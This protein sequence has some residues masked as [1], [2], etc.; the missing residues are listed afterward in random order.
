MGYPKG[1][2]GAA[3]DRPEPLLIVKLDW[4]H[5]RHFRRLTGIRM[6][7]SV[8]LKPVRFRVQP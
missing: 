5:R 6:T 2:L 8:A 7:W 4:R 3:N 1:A